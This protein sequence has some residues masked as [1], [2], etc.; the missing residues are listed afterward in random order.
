[1]KWAY[2]KGIIGGVDATHFDPD[3]QC[4]R[5]LFVEVLCKYNEIYKILK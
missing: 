3:G 2:K 1:M 5:A 4:S